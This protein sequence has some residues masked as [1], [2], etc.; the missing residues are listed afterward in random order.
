MPEV[1]EIVRELRE[2]ADLMRQW[3]TFLTPGY[4][5][6]GPDDTRY[7][8]LL[9]EISDLH[10]LIADGWMDTLTSYH[11]DRSKNVFDVRRFVITHYIRQVNGVNGGYTV[12]LD[13]VCAQSINRLRRH[14]CTR[15]R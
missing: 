8:E 10:S 1:R 13:S 3:V 2:H 4:E 15:R 14:R 12:M 6:A 9:S 7:K 11:A 5:D